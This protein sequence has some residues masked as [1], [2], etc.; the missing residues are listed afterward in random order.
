MIMDETLEIADAVSIAGA[1]ATALVGDQIDLRQVSGAEI[2]D[3][4]FLVIQI[5]VAVAG[6]TSAQFTLASDAAAA[7]ATD[8]SATVHWASRIFPVAELPLG[9]RIIV[10][11]PGG[12]PVTERY[13]GLLVTRVGTLSAGTIDAFLTTD[14]QRWQAFPDAVN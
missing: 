10:P 11:L 1:A 8:G 7:I 13:L 4:L 6:G 5:N 14:A 9:R 12:I 2:F 3:S